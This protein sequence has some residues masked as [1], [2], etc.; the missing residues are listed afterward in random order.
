MS[1]VLGEKRSIFCGREDRADL[2]AVVEDRVLFDDD[3]DSV[4]RFG[5]NGERTHVGAL[6]QIV[7]AVVDGEELGLGGRTFI[8]T[9]QV[10]RAGGERNGR[11]NDGRIGGGGAGE[12]D[13]AVLVDGEGDVGSAVLTGLERDGL[14]QVV[15]IAF[16]DDLLDRGLLDVLPLEVGEALGE[17]AERDDQEKRN[18]DDDE[19]VAGRFSEFHVLTS[20]Q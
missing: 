18:G 8:V 6:D 14:D 15:R 11:I 12:L 1:L 13:S 3:L 4:R 17:S 20:F 16:L 7:R 9:G 5:R 10:V 2:D 19:G